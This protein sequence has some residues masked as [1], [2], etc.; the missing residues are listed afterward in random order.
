VRSVLACAALL[1]VLA[2]G[3]CSG[4]PPAPR[5]GAPPAPRSS[6]PPV[7]RASA[8]PAP[9]ASAPSA[10]PGRSAPGASAAPL[11]AHAR[12]GWPMARASYLGRY[13]MTWSSDQS[14]ARSGLL[15]LFMRQVTKPKAMIVP[16]GIMS[17]FGGDATTVLYLTKFGHLGSR[18]VAD[19]NVGLYTSSPVGAVELTA[20]S[21]ASHTLTL[22]LAAAG[23]QR[24]EM[25]FIR[26]SANPHP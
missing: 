11:S 15:T 17:V 21:V 25:R 2:A 14:F 20:F 7:P 9:R 13:R 8:P 4:A 10:P 3:A 26:Y 24:V 18:A 12:P 19:V 6:A 23:R 5:S 22:V 1:A 16:S